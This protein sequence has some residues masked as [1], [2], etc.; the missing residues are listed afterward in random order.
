MI[1]ACI[2]NQDAMT[3]ELLSRTANDRSSP[4]SALLRDGHEHDFARGA[5]AFDKV[6]CN[7]LAFGATIANN[8][9]ARHVADPHGVQRRRVASP[10][11]TSTASAWI[12]SRF[13]SDEARETEPKRAS[14]RQLQEAT[15]DLR[16]GGVEVGRGDD[17]DFGQEGE[18]EGGGVTEADDRE[19]LVC[20]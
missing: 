9:I 20:S 1:P 6:A 10:R 8:Q 7:D 18:G 12:L 2:T 4:Y 16:G 15:G 17:V 19:A 11:R 14:V 3:E 5:V 13:A